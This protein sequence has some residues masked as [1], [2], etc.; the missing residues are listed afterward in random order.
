MRHAARLSISFLTVWSVLT[1]CQA[2]NRLINSKKATMF[3]VEQIQA[4]HS[5]IKSGADFPAYVQNIK[6]L[7]VMSYDTY[8]SDGH[9]DYYGVDGFKLSSPAKYAALS[10]EDISNPQQFKTDLLAHQ[11]GNSD[12]PTFCEQSAQSGVEKWVVSME[13]M[14][15]TYFNKKGNKI[16]VEQVP[17]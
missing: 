4:A 14:T 2:T 10:V 15:C 3:T 8:V 9:T 17:Q 16:L 12:Y 6:A 7:G 5:Q 13:E 11:Q 1:A